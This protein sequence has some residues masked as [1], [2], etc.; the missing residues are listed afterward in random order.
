MSCRP[1]SIFLTHFAEVTEL[2]RLAREMKERVL[3]FADLGA[4]LRDAPDRSTKL[5]RGM[6]AMIGAWLDAHGFPRDEA[7]RRWL[8]DND[9]E[10]NCQGIEVWLDRK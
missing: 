6:F 10:L 7:R 4:R 9:I 1:R 2:E 5:R 8:L 3:A